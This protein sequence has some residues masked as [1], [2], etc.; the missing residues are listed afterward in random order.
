[1][2]SLGEVPYPRGARTLG[3]PFDGTQT[4]TVSLTA[5]PGPWM[6]PG[7]GGGDDEF[8]LA[9]AGATPGATPVTPDPNR[10]LAG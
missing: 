9:A 5:R 3:A 4:V 10:S 8:S 2:V 7:L 1:M 6:V